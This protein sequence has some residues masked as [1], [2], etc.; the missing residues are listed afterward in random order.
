MKVSLSRKVLNRL[1]DSRAILHAGT[2]KLRSKLLR[3][4]ANVY[5]ISNQI[6]RNP[7]LF[8]IDRNRWTRVV[9][10]TAQTM[11]CVTAC[12]DEQKISSQLDELERLV[13]EA[14]TKK[15]TG[16]TQ[17]CVTFNGKD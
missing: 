15:E 6:A 13:N 7:N 16:K 9:A 4:L 12:F 14:T 17:K 10:H 5:E 8:Q 11:N 3:K 1:E 2:R